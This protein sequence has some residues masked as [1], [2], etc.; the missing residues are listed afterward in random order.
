[1]NMHVD[2]CIIHEGVDALFPSQECLQVELG[3]FLLLT[4]S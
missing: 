3:G 4:V 2:V 1:M